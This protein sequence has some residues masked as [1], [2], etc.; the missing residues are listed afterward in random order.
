MR[1]L[2]RLIFASAAMFAACYSQ[3][4]PVHAPPTVAAAEGS[5][6]DVVCKDEVPM[7]SLISRVVCRP[8]PLVN[9][10]DDAGLMNELQHPHNSPLLP[11][12]IW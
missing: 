8:K 1:T 3:P 7:G 4:P 10:R 11:T 5:G 6:S 2:N 12:L 9:P